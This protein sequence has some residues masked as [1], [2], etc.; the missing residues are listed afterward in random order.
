MSIALTIMPFMSFSLMSVMAYGSYLAGLWGA[1]GTYG[2]KLRFL[3]TRLQYQGRT[4]S[5]KNVFYNLCENPTKLLDTLDFQ[6]YLVHLPLFL[7]ALRF[8]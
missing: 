4:P 6:G 2:K 1:A 5:K 3:N 7:C 8:C